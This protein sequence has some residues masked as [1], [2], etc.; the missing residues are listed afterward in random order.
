MHAGTESHPLV[1]QPGLGMGK[2]SWDGPREHQDLENAVHQASRESGGGSRNRQEES[3]H[4]RSVQGY[5]TRQCLQTAWDGGAW[6]WLWLLTLS[7][8]AAGT[9]VVSPCLVGDVALLRAPGMPCLTSQ[10]QMPYVCEP[11]PCGTMH[12]WG[13]GLGLVL[14]HSQHSQVM[15][16]GR[17]GHGQAPVGG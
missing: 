8:S 1:R 3:T 13:P 17:R 15:G 6:A 7:V 2:M 12:S 5:R 4:S 9:T 16:V 11:V 14:Q 10:P